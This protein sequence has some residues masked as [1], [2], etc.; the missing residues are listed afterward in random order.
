MKLNY[1]DR[2]I[3]GVLLALVLLLG[4]F[5]LLIK[6]ANEDIKTNKA[7]LSTLEQSK[8]EVD[9]KIA[10]IPGIKTDIT[11]SYN[12]GIGFTET[13]VDFNNFNNPRKLDQYMQSFA[14]E[15]EVKIMTLSAESMTEGG[16]EYYYFA[17]SFV[18][19]EMRSQADIN[20]T[21]AEYIA[22]EKAESDA[23]SD[24]TEE[25]VIQAKYT[26]QVTG[27]EKENIWNYMAALEEQ[28]ETILINSVALQ[29]IV[30]KEIEEEETAEEEDEEEKLPTATFTI[31]L[32]SVYV[33]DEPNLEMA[34]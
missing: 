19:E 31:T 22:Q 30:L 4:G 24:R 8:A 26:I 13:F 7:T 12:K 18:A 20:G 29:N 28:D 14:E 2:I 10:E 23:L 25:E 6:P 34:N 1:R 27:E 32:Y 11:E 3:L 5:F 16:L 21:D 17:P 15:N 33:M 9:T